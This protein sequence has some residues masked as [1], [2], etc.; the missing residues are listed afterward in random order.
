MLMKMRLFLGAFLIL[1][2]A[3]QAAMAM[4]C[5]QALIVE[6][7]HMLDVYRKCGEPYFKETRVEY[8]AVR[9]RSP[10]LEQERWIPVNVEE[11]TYNFGPSR[12]METLL[13]EGSRVVGSRTL[14]YGD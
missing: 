4:R 6:G 10:G 8:R 5:G 2:S 14:G 1:F 9:L 7:D 13:F 12:F 3:T 11:W